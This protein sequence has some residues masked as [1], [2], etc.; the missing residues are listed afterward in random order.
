MSNT[1]PLLQKEF[2]LAAHP[3][4]YVFTLLGCLVIVPNY[5][6]S[7]VF[8]F[9]CLAPYITF[10]N[11]RENQDSFYTALL[12]VRKRDVVKSKC[13]LMVLVELGQLAIS[14]PFAFLRTLLLPE[15]NIVGIEANVAYYGFGLLVYG[16]FNLIFFT[17]FYKTAYK[18][19]KA[20]LFAIV[21]AMLVTVFM[22][23]LVHVPGAQ[24][25]DSV[26]PS[27]LLMQLPVLAAGTV[28][29]AAFTVTAYRIAA[30]RFESVDL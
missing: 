26:A 24:W 29:Y 3:T 17:E 7:A 18:V 13:L 12:P 20:F 15:G 11:A 23:V 30:K 28:V 25:L 2:R 21:P 19:G 10:L 5:P 27:M 16:I 6:Y 1:L 8:L 4:L 22:E 14:L 9:G